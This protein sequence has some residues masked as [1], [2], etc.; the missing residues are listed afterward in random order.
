MSLHEY[1]EGKE[2][3]AKDPPFYALIQAAMRRADTANLHLLK[4][5]WPEVWL[6]LRA[7]YN[8]PGAILQSELKGDE[9]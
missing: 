3:A 7:R 9:K 6:E 8:A 1:E 5:C 2:I 4:A